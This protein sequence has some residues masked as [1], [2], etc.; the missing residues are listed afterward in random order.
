MFLLRS[1]TDGKKDAS[2]PIGTNRLATVRHT[3]MCYTY[4]H[5]CCSIY[6]NVRCYRIYSSIRLRLSSHRCWGVH[7]SM[8]M[9]L[10]NR[11]DG[12][13]GET[14]RTYPELYFT[15]L[16]S[17]FIVFYHYD[18][19]APWEERIFN[20]LIALSSIDLPFEDFPSSRLESNRKIYNFYSQILHIVHFLWFIIYL[21]ILLSEHF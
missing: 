19:L 10:C 9:P 2:W 15:S 14:A 4:I 8:A 20:D 5:L 12:C 3:Y 13:A 1:I 6:A 7:Y 16:K 21:L 11:L 18:S 17:H